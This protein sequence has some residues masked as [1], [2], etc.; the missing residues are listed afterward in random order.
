MM[1]AWADCLDELR[2]AGKVIPLRRE[3]P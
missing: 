2:E 1:Q 3:R